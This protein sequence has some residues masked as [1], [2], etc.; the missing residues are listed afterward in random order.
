MR[1]PLFFILMLGF[2]ACLYPWPMPFQDQSSLEKSD[3]EKQRDLVGMPVQDLVSLF[4]E[5]VNKGRTAIPR[6]ILEILRGQG[7][8]AEPAIPFLLQVAEE[9]FCIDLSGEELKDVDPDDEAVFVYMWRYKI[10]EVYPEGAS[11][12]IDLTQEAWDVLESIGTPATLALIDA[13][14]RQGKAPYFM[15][16]KIWDF[17]PSTFD[18]VESHAA[19]LRD[20]DERMRTG[21]AVILSNLGEK[22]YEAVLALIR[23]DDPGLRLA[24][25]RAAMA[26]DDYG[27]SLTPILSS[28][29]DDDDPAL[30]RAAAFTLGR[31]IPF[32]LPAL[33]NAF[34]NEDKDVRRTAVEAVEKAFT[35]SP[36]SHESVGPGEF[37]AW[38]EPEKVVWDHESLSGLASRGISALRRALED[39]SE[40]VRVFAAIALFKLARFASD[41]VEELERARED[42]SPVVRY[43]ADIAL[44]RHCPIRWQSLRLLAQQIRGGDEPIPLTK[45]ELESL[46]ERVRMEHGWEFDPHANDYPWPGEEDLRWNAAVELVRRELPRLLEAEC[47]ADPEAAEG[48]REILNLLEWA[49]DKRLFVLMRF[50]DKDL[51]ECCDPAKETLAALGKAALPALAYDYLRYPRFPLGFVT[52]LDLVWVLE[53]NGIDGLPI[54][55][56]GLEHWWPDGRYHA[57]SAIRKLGPAA[58]PA[59]PAIISAWRYDF[60]TLPGP[61][62]ALIWD[63]DDFTLMVAGLGAKALPW[64][65][66]ALEDDLA[67]VRAR[68]CRNIGALGADARHL[69]PAL[70]ELMNYSEKMVRLE[71]ARAFLEA[72]PENDQRVLHARAVLRELER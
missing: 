48:A 36:E 35:P 20:P 50:V 22:G 60:I 57:A 70:A 21:A 67:V 11:V 12:S 47:G 69:L 59:A 27:K 65:E 53:Q 28:L 7:P 1:I 13:T 19:L 44:K 30:R 56:N 23:S 15:T 71:A 37:A 55:V 40:E 52:H 25:V 16:S 46:V 34:E 63:E 31:L 14:T 49:L 72:A 45:E 4:Q 29:L 8:K 54:L 2:I 17:V 62:R 58:F 5:E 10:G 6:S 38:H 39:E 61:G 24:G 43:W 3:R 51:Y 42:S 32:S 64:L 33:F 68:A 9:R 26:F 66:R 18:A 41:A